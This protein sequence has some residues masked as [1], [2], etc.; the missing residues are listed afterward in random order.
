MWYVWQKCNLNLQKSNKQVTSLKG[1]QIPNSGSNADEAGKGPWGYRGRASIPRWICHT[2]SQGHQ[3][4]VL[5]L[6][7][8]S[9]KSRESGCEAWGVTNLWSLLQ[10]T[11]AG[12]DNPYPEPS[13]SHC[14]HSSTARWLFLNFDREMAV[15]VNYNNNNNN[16]NALYFEVFFLFLFGIQSISKTL[17]YLPNRPARLVYD[18]SAFYR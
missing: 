10:T 4:E 18:Y 9:G 8:C 2:I 14:N 3:N 17:G 13:L 1:A 16:Y 12:C 6:W 15:Q 7:L 5:A 11:G